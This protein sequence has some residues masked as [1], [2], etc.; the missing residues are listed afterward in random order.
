MRLLGYSCRDAFNKI[1]TLK[2]K[3]PAPQQGV[4][5]LQLRYITPLCLRLASELEFSKPQAG[6]LAPDLPYCNEGQVTCH[7]YLLL[8]RL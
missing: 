2:L 5:A 8:H 4:R 6:Q 3:K 1:L 7:H